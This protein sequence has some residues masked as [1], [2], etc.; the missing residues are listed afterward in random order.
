MGKIKWTEKSSFDLQSI[1]EYIS[2]DS[3]IYAVRFVKSLVKATKRLEDMPLS[4]RIVPEF[5]NKEF[6]EIIFRNY[7]IVYRL[8]GRNNDVEILAVVHGARDMKRLISKEW[9]L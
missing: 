1:H 2:K 6:R 7:R 5:E 8:V 3:K 4:G 9:E